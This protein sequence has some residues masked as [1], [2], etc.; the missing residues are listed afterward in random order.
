MS[1]RSRSSKNQ[2]THRLSDR[3]SL[4][5]SGST[6]NKSSHENTV[7]KDLPGISIH[8]IGDRIASTLASRLPVEEILRSA[9]E[10]PNQQK[11]T[12]LP[13]TDAYISLLGGSDYVTVKSAHWFLASEVNHCKSTS[14]DVILSDLFIRPATYFRH[15][16]TG[17]LILVDQEKLFGVVQVRN[18]AYEKLVT[19][20]ASGDKW[21]SYIDQPAYYITS[22]ALP[23]TSVDTSDIF[24]FQFSLPDNAEAFEFA[25]H[26]RWGPDENCDSA[27]DNNAGQ[28]YLLRRIPSTGEDAVKVNHGING[29]L[30]QQQHI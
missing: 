21:L 22:N 6:D 28:N 30:I 25:I 26:Y 4:R 5:E 8:A 27:W 2:S 12:C 7:R 1:V 13:G 3:N 14:E 29:D 24:V 15:N 20:R 17:K 23:D 9:K 19:V 18:H 16:S 10:V 11:T